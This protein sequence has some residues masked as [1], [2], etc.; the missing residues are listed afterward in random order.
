VARRPGVSVAAL[1]GVGPPVRQVVRKVVVVH[2]FIRTGERL[3]GVP[4]RVPAGRP[5]GRCRSGLKNPSH[6]VTER[7]ESE[8]SERI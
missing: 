3:N 4:S 6:T 5:S 2:R 8:H 7:R 1:D